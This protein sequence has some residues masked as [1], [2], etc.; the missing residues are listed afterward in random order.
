MGVRPARPADLR[1]LAEIAEISQADPERFVGYVGDDAATIA[2]EVAEVEDWAA[3]TWIAEDDGIVGW[4]LAERDDAMGRAWLWG[5][6]LDHAD[7]AAWGEVADQLLAVA[8][9]DVALPEQELACDQRSE[10]FRALADRV[11]FS[12]DPASVLLRLDPADARLDAGA[13]VVIVP[14]SDTWAEAVAEL[15][16]QLFPGTHTPGRSLVEAH[17]DRRPRYVALLDGEPVGY[18]ALEHQ[19]DGSAYVDFLGVDPT[20]RQRGIGRVLVA[21]AVAEA[22][23]GG[24][25]LAHLTVREANA[26]ARALYASLGFVEERVLQPYRKGFTLP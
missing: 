2:A 7:P 23:A 21:H 3:T 10:R 22:L 4:L 12:A 1:R 15:H 14:L 5:P 18:V 9:Q 26:A 11:G 20:H 25:T 8:R 6:F 17:D 24:A 19:P 13:D 16:D